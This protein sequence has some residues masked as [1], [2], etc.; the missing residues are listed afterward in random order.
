MFVAFLIRLL[1]G[2]GVPLPL[3]GGGVLGIVKV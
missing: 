1:F 3:L 2:G